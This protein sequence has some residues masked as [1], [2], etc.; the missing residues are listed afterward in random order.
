ML[1]FPCFRKSAPSLH[2]VCSEKNTVPFL[3]FLFLC[4]LPSAHISLSCIRVSRFHILLGHRFWV[5][6]KWLFLFCTRKETVDRS[7]VI[8]FYRYL[9]LICPMSLSMEQCTHLSVLK[10]KDCR[11]FNPVYYL[12]KFWC[13][14]SRV[15]SLKWGNVG[16]REWD[17]MPKIIHYW[18]V[19]K[20]G[21][22]LRS[23]LTAFASWLFG[24]Y[25]EYL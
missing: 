23:K 11:Y 13:N 3:I 6:E 19:N 21:F 17:K 9:P 15:H 24:T 14:C 16:T 10:E 22:D 4:Y 25:L 1:R 12:Q 8:F 2:S 7:W 18:Y 20:L 5:S